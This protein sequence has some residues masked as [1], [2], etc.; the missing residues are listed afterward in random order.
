MNDFILL[1]MCWLWLAVCIV[2]FVVEACTLSLTTV[3][4][5]VSAFLMI[6]LSLFKINLV[7]QIFVFVVLSM[8]LLIFT[9]PVLA[10]KL[11]VKKTPTNSDSLIQKE[12]VV[13]K[14]ITPLSKGQVKIA[15]VG[16]E[17]QAESSDSSEIPV[18]THCIIEEIRGATVIVSERP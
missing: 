12:C 10:K 3:W 11:S 1:N 14:E 15:G 13:T 18:G 2:C 4:F 7:V 6:F 5:G 16:V 9:R 17:W 8:L